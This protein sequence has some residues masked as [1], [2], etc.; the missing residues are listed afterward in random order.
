MIGHATQGTAAGGPLPCR[1]MEI[2]SGT[3][4]LLTGASKGIGRATAEALAQRGARV[5]LN[6]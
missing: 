3:R 2:G 5:A 4:V 1:A 6:A